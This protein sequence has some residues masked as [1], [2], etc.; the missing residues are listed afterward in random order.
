MDLNDK[1]VF[2]HWYYFYLLPSTFYLIPSTYY[3]Y[4]YYY[5]VPRIAYTFV[6]YMST[7][8]TSTFT[9]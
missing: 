8:T 3:Y 1:V 7:S 5:I 6:T 4:Y 2:V 9:T